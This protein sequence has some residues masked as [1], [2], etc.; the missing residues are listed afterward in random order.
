VV[1]ALLRAVGAVHS[2]RRLA[3]QAILPS[4]QEVVPIVAKLNTA[5]TWLTFEDDVAFCRITG[6]LN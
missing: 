3:E 4:A 5:P 1:G 2:L 6:R